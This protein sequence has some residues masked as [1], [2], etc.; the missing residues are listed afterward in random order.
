MPDKASACAASCP[1][2]P[3]SG[4][5]CPSLPS[6]FPQLLAEYVVS[7]EHL[8]HPIGEREVAAASPCFPVWKDRL[9]VSMFASLVVQLGSPLIPRVLLGDS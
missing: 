6:D 9:R 8:D 5:R 7:R 3:R 2:P 4:D 1:Y